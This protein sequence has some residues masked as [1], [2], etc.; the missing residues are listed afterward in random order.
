MLVAVSW[1]W[2]VI[3][4]RANEVKLFSV[5]WCHCKIIGLNSDDTGADDGYVADV[6]YNGD[7]DNNNKPSKWVTAGKSK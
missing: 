4:F 3:W 6:D 1:I 7:D 5:S 2:I